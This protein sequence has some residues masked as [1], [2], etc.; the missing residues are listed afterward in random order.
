MRVL[1]GTFAPRRQGDVHA[2]DDAG[3]GGADDASAG[4]GTRATIDA[5]SG[6]ARRAPTRQAVPAPPPAPS[7]THHTIVMPG[8]N[9]AFAAV[10]ET[11][12]L[13]GANAQPQARAMTTAFLRDSDEVE[14]RPVTFVFNGGPGAASA[15]LDLG[16]L[17]PW[18]VKMT[19]EAAEPSA[20]VV[21]VDNAETWLEFTDLVF[22]DTP[23]TGYA[24]LLAD[25]EEARKRFWVVE[26]DVSGIAE[27]IRRWLLTHHRM[28]SPKYVVGESYDGIR[29]PRVVL[30]LTM[31]HGVGVRGLVL[32][33]PVMDYG[34]SAV[35]DP[36]SWVWALPS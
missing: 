30:T 11:M 10:V 33:S 27:T 2:T 31:E 29:G 3:H 13:D 19:P 15:W 16:A 28:A 21:A 26:G 7:V 5:G 25:N 23:G 20:D 22:I 4:A 1:C 35:F 8:G 6:S 17:G 36:F 24:R 9:I 34:T 18:R 14:R 32:V 12:T